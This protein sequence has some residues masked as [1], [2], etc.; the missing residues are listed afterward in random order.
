V[1]NTTSL[2]YYET[3]TGKYL[4]Y[5]VNSSC[6]LRLRTQHAK[7]EQLS[8]KNSRPADN[9]FAHFDKIVRYELNIT[10]PRL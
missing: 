1:K 9:I 6:Y 3:V 4:S 5:F 8:S 10:E 2:F 7:L